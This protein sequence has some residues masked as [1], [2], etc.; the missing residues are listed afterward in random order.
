[1]IDDLNMKNYAILY[2]DLGKELISLLQEKLVATNEKG[3]C[4]DIHE[5]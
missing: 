2:I 5:Y 4:I 3:V 1:M